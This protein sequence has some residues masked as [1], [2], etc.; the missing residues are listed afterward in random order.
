VADRPRS[1]FA[2]DVDDDDAIAALP[3]CL[4]VCP[5]ACAPHR[6]NFL[7]RVFPPGVSRWVINGGSLFPSLLSLGLASRRESRDAE[8]RRPTS[9]TLSLAIFSIKVRT[10]IRRRPNGWPN[11]RTP[12]ASFIERKIRAILVA[13]VK[14]LRK[15]AMKFKNLA[16]NVFISNLRSNCVTRR[17][18]MFFANVI[19]IREYYSPAVSR[20]K[21][22]QWNIALAQSISNSSYDN[23]ISH[24]IY[25]PPNIYVSVCNALK[26]H[27]VPMLMNSNMLTSNDITIARSFFT[28]VD[29]AEG[30]EEKRP[31]KRRSWNSCRATPLLRGLNIE[32]SSW[33]S[34]SSATYKCRSVGRH[35]I[36]IRCDYAR[37]MRFFYRHTSE[38][39]K[40]RTRSAA[41][42]T[43]VIIEQPR[44]L[45]F[46]ASPLESLVFSLSS[47]DSTTHFLLGPTPMSSDRPLLPLFFFFFFSANDFLDHSPWFDSGYKETRRHGP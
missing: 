9:S 23:K 6:K 38:L 28:I 29:S 39:S 17:D 3:T 18:Y 4:P 45:F 5:P 10:F 22:R 33:L 35:E 31:R 34:L 41:S 30:D 25:V 43:Y 26:A 15:G 21:M 32:L 7:S 42:A 13:S 14:K 11:S 20:F 40:G 19:G 36:L 8:R 47:F 44:S 16:S 1:P 37:D 46:L 2:I 24:N 12:A 27:V